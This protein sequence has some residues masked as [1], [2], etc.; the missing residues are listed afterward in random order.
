MPTKNPRVNVTFTESD[1]EIIQ[2]ICKRKRMSMSALVRKV[3]EDW[4]EDYEDSL[5]SAK[6]DQAIERWE[7]NGK[8]TIS[9][10]DLWKRVNS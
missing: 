8:K 4:I 10:E 2:I 6:A 3:M 9:H 5:L 1:A 7:E